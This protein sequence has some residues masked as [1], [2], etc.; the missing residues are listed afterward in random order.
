VYGSGVGANFLQLLQTVNKG[1]PLP[2]GGIHNRRSLLYIGNL[3]DA[4]LVVLKHPDAANKL[5]LLSDGHDVSTSQLV[6]LIA[7]ALNKPPRLFAVPQGLLRL[8]AIL[9]GKSSAVDRLFGSLYLD[10]AKIGQELGWVPPFSMQDGL[11][12][13]AHVLL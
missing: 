1:W 10:S 3:V 12:E 9:M 2:L 4:I 6:E 5:Y 11:N 8:V 13:T 7:K